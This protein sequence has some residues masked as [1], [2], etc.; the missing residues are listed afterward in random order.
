[1]TEL[2]EKVNKHAGQAFT[3]QAFSCRRVERLRKVGLVGKIGQ[4]PARIGPTGALLRALL[5]AKFRQERL[6]FVTHRTSLMHSGEMA[7]S[8]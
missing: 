6:V 2:S 8:L 5:V 1:M 7:A 3:V 4:R